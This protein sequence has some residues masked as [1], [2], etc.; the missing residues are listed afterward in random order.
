MK[1]EVKI[2]NNVETLVD[3]KTVITESNFDA[4]LDAVNMLTGEIY[5]SLPTYKFVGPDPVEDLTPIPESVPVP[6]EPDDSDDSDDCQT[7]TG[8]VHLKCK[9]C[10][11]VKSFC[12]REGISEFRC[13]ECGGDTPLYHLVKIEYTCPE[14]GR[15]HWYWTN[16]TALDFVMQCFDCGTD[17]PVTYS[18]ETN[19][20]VGGTENV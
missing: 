9:H 16:E 7:Y 6:D 12:S 4:V 5:N 10:G 8:F 13:K 3:L 14:C 11:A 2:K 1:L 19:S 17:I 15:K 18:E 20:Y